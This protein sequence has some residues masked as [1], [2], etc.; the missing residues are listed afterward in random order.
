MFVTGKES[1]TA[2][3]L[4]A[5]KCA[6]SHYSFNSCTNV[7]ELFK[8][9]F[10]DSKIAQKFTMSPAKVAYMCCFGI[11]PYF[12]VLLNQLIAGQRFV[13]LF[14]ETLNRSTQTKQLDLLV[15]FWHPHLNEVTTKYLNSVFLG[16]S[17]ATDILKGIKNALID[18]DFCNIVQISMDGPAVNFK[19]YATFNE[20][21]QNEFQHQILNIGTCGLH[22][23]HNAVKVG[24]SLS[25]WNLDLFF[26]CIYRLFKDSPARAEDYKRLSVTGKMPVKFCRHRWLDNLPAVK[27]ALAILDDL[28]LFVENVQNKKIPNPN[29]FSY[30]EMV[31]FLQDKF[32]AVKLHFF[33][34]LI[35]LIQPFLTIYQTDNPMLPFFAE[36][37][38]KIIRSSFINFSILKEG[39]IK[40][41]TISTLPRFE[42]NK[43]IYN[44]ASKV[45]LGF[46]GDRLV[47]SL[48]QEAKISETEIISLKQQAQEFVF[49]MVSKIL[50]KSPLKFAVVRNMSCLNPKIMAKDKEKCAEKFKSLLNY[51]SDCG[52]I[53][54]TDG[55]S[56]LLDFKEFLTNIN[57]TEF[58]NFSSQKD[59]L[60]HFL[61]EQMYKKGYL[62]VWE[63]IRMLLLLSHG[64]ASVERGF[65]VNKQIEVDNLKEET[66]VSLRL[67]YDYVH[68]CGGI[69]KVPIT[70]EL[71]SSAASG[72]QRYYAYLAEEKKKKD[73]TSKNQRKRKIQEDL[74][75][76]KTKRKNI[77]GD[78]KKLIKSADELSI[79]AENSRKMD[80]C[81][82]SN[83]LRKS[84][85]DKESELLIIND[86]IDR[87]TKE[88]K[89]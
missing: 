43:N 2:E 76:L 66:Y 49:A 47:K 7:C 21:I 87:K 9:M 37:L 18:L 29:N 89:G 56:I 20:Q 85:K 10:S 70:K 15:K 46:S 33:H 32:L 36:D 34:S 88:L 81:V 27:R 42:C 17:T 12:R 25:G 54:D 59:R 23:L 3:V 75:Q 24:E 52:H 1:L 38:T 68:F 5:L 83:S 39:E 62:K 86:E 60:D 6:T 48:L 8:V 64:Q 65:S 11:A 45:S 78:I 26:S 61:F 55:E 35:S 80:Y 50:E 77:E 19:M 79:L 84:A 74:E 13:L 4:W 71:L 58:A 14:D 28:K 73:E 30:N 16:H 22:V 31:K 57:V 82:Q 67:I 63:I 51:L 40:K 41:I 53:K 69:M 44:S 72:R